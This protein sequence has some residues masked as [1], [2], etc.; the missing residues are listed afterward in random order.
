MGDPLDTQT[1]GA[2]VIE[3]TAESPVLVTSFSGNRD[4]WTSIWISDFAVDASFDEDGNYVGGTK[5]EHVVIDRGGVERR[6]DNIDGAIALDG[7]TPYIRGVLRVG[8]VQ[9]RHVGRHRRDATRVLGDD[10]PGPDRGE[11]LGRGEQRGPVVH[12]V[13]SAGSLL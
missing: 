12:A 9:L 5:L 3:G 10:G 7:G 2:L 1:P 11:D 13:R 6:D 8:G 4:Y